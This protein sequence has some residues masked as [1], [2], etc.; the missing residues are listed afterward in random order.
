M[1]ERLL[2]RA[3]FLTASCDYVMDERPL[4]LE[5]FFKTR[6]CYLQMLARRTSHR[7]HHCGLDP[8]LLRQPFC[9]CRHVTYE[10]AYIAASGDHF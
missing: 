4:L 9:L 6:V 8:D 2:N 7:L 3:K 1:S 10:A 5:G